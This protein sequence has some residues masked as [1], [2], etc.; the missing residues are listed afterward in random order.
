MTLRNVPGRNAA[1]FRF[2]RTVVAVTAAFLLTISDIGASSVFAQA[3][4]LPRP[5][6]LAQQAQ[7]P[8]KP[9]ASQPGILRSIFGRKRDA[10]ARPSPFSPTQQVALANIS[11][12]FNSFR[13]ME[14][15]FIQVGPNGEQSEGVFVID[16][17]GKIRFHYKP[18][19]QLDVVADGRSVA[20]RNNR[21]RTQDL[22]PLRKTPL[23]YLLSDDID[24]T[25]SEIVSEI[26]EEVDLI[27]LIIIEKSTLVKGKLT[28][29]F[30]RNSFEL[31]QW[32][33]TDAQGLNTS[34]AIFNTVTGIRPDPG[35]F[36]ITVAPQKKRR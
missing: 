29:I 21:A 25:S 33:V 7:A 4:P 30:D 19:V 36:R 10:P 22:Y 32:I 13:T 3:I 28:L 23:R 26:R 17:P 15:K 14:G 8:A 35:L 12:Y 27:S 11:N 9:A 2:P 34:V 5:N 31:R 6:P 24:L 16:K 20:I 18:P 1:R